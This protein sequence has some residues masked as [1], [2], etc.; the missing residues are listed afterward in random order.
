MSATIIVQ[1]DRGF[2]D[3]FRAYRIFL[4][5]EP[6]GLLKRKSRLELDVAPGARRIGAAIDWCKAKDLYVN[7]IEGECLF[8]RVSNTYGAFKS[9]SAITTN[10]DTYLTLELVEAESPK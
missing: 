9:G 5:G 4:D 8:L 2:C 7:A 10:A 3:F 6:V 1:R